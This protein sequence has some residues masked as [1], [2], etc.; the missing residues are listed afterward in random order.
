MTVPVAERALFLKMFFE[1][2][3]NASPAAREFCRIKKLRR[4]PMPTKSG[5]RYPPSTRQRCPRD[6][7]GRSIQKSL[8]GYLPSS[9]IRS[10]WTAPGGQIRSPLLTPLTI[11][12]VFLSSMGYYYKG[13]QIP[14]VDGGESESTQPRYGMCRSP[15]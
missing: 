15:R 13:K 1:N 14:N 7:T 2:D 5:R 11:R 3:M 4:G 9:Q 8:E 10:F 12:S 6:K